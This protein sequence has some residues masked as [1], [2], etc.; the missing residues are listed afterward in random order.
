LFFFQRGKETDRKLIVRFA[1]LNA[2]L[3]L[4]IFIVYVIAI[5][6]INAL[7]CILEG[8]DKDVNECLKSSNSIFVLR[9]HAE[10]NTKNDRLGGLSVGLVHMR[11][12]LTTLIKL[13]S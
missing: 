1:T 5:L 9:L 8:G 12:H 2:S 11:N 3:Y 7:S 4:F 6:I 13:V 10:M